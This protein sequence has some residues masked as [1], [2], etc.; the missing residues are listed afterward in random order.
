MISANN[1]IPIEKC[2]IS[3]S[4]NKYSNRQEAD[5]TSIAKAER[6]I[7]TGKQGVSHLILRAENDDIDRLK[8]LFLIRGIPVMCYAL[9]N[10]LNSSLREIVVVGSEEVKEVME[11]FLAVVGT[12]GKTI[13]FAPEDAQHLNLVHTLELGRN[14]LS[15]APNELVL[16][17]PGDLPFLYDLEKVLRFPDNKKYNLILW[18]NSRQKM[19]P[20]FASNPE[21]EFVKRNYHYRSI[22]D[23]ENDLHDL[24]EPNLFPINFSRMDPDII[25]RLHS[26]RKDGQIIHAGIQTALKNPMRLLKVLPHVANHLFTFRKNVNRIRPGDQYQF[27]MSRKNFNKGISCL[28]NTPLTI[29]LHNDPAFV[30][31]VDALEDWEDFESI[32]HYAEKIHGQEGLSIIHPLG[33]ALTRFR[34]E[35]MPELH[36][37]IPMYQDFPSYLN[38]IYE[39]LKM[40]CVPFSADGQYISPNADLKEVELAYHWYKDKCSLQAE[41]SYD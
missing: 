3:F 39:T 40:D 6:E 32:T 15:P 30:S 35:G 27:G 37:K 41:T 29:T 18:L 38:S 22:Y 24:K 2:I 14:L 10:L 7:A 23:D 36:E 1:K 9:A 8:F 33:E 21:S 25:D 19:F 16:F 34:D 13:R 31:D 11:H 20:D 28:L 26:S 5:A 17:Q 12:C 4:H